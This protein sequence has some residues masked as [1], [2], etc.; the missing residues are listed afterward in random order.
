MGSEEHEDHA[1]V[2]RGAG[3][4]VVLIGLIVATFVW[5][6]AV[7]GTELATFG[8][9]VLTT[10]TLLDTLWLTRASRGA[11]TVA[12]TLGAFAIAGSAIALAVD[13]RHARSV[14][15]TMLVLLVTVAPAALLR[16]I[17]RQPVIDRHTVG[18]VVSLYLLLGMLFATLF[19]AIDAISSAP[20]FVDVPDANYSDFIY[21]SYVTLTTVGYG[22]LVAS[23]DLGR[24]LGVT[25]A[26]LGQIYLV[27][28]VALVV[29]NVG[30]ARRRA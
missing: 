17:A 29:G 12:A 21:F 18:A 25:E 27:T 3:G 23:L 6:M 19:S 7:N 13:W 14:V 5:G 1:L 24:A 4:F 20:F 15:A 22:D 26:L 16:A 9:V 8:L 11:L 10:A 2:L 30:R 28:V